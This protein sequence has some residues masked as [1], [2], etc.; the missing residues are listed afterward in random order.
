MLWNVKNAAAYLGISGSMVYKL[1]Y[2]K[3]LSCVRIGGSIRFMPEDV[4]KLVKDNTVETNSGKE[5]YL[6]AN[7]DINFNSQFM[8]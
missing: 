6:S 2:D 4:D 5:N 1:V 7:K 3:S 8:L